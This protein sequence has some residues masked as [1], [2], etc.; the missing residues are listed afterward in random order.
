MMRMM[1]SQLSYRCRL[2]VRPPPRAMTAP[3]SAE[4]PPALLPVH[5]AR[6]RQDLAPQ[7]RQLRSGVPILRGGG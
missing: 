3:A 4:Q 6:H 5:T 2:R 7:P 1:C